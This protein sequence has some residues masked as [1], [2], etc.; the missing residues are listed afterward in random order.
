MSLSVF[1]PNKTTREKLYLC[2]LLHLGYQLHKGYYGKQK[3]LFNAR[4]R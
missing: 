1:I 4:F 3:S 2:Y